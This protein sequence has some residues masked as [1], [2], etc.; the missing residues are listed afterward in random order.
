MFS[1]SFTR[2]RVL[3]GA[4]V[5]LLALTMATSSVSSAGASPAGH[6]TRLSVVTTASNRASR[7]GMVLDNQLGALQILQNAATAHPRSYGGVA[8]QGTAR[9]TVHT[10]SGTR[11]TPSVANAVRT[12][13]AAGT[14]VTFDRTTR[15]LAQLQTAMGHVMAS[16]SVKALGKSLQSWGVDVGSNTIQLGVTA[17]VPGATQR[18]IQAQFGTAVTFK[19]FP[20]MYEFSTRL[21]DTTPY[22]GGDRIFVPGGA[23]TSAFTITNAYGNN[24]SVTAAHCGDVGDRVTTNG[25][26]SGSRTFGT[27]DYNGIQNGAKLDAALVGT[28]NRV[29]YTWIGSVS[30]NMAQPDVSVK[31]SCTGCTVDYD[32][33]YTGQANGAKLVGS[34]QSIRL[35]EGDGSNCHTTIDN[36]IT[37]STG[38]RD[39]QPGDSGG[40]VIVGNGH[41]Q[42]VAVG[43]IRGGSADGSECI[44]TQLP[45]V[46]AYWKSTLT[47]S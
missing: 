46:L 3:S 2:P 29:G 47:N 18:A 9:V 7:E 30:N 1:A 31:N 14:R 37:E 20:R 28:N 4:A 25:T 15:S 12:L 10:I 26:T 13:R 23:C 8:T 11:L 36:Q 33:S 5:G 41:A 24:Y 21:T 17:P 40:P 42:I 16:R 34:P 22:F 35:C 45:P 19:L 6:A 38:G 27:L 32:G 43:I 44:Y 39:C